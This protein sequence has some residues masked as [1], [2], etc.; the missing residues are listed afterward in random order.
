MH[1]LLCYILSYFALFPNYRLLLSEGYQPDIVYTSRLK[2]AVRSTWTVLEEIDSFYLPVYK[3]WRLNE[4]SYGA[5]TGLSKTETA[6]KLGSNV[7]QAWRNSLKARP[8]LM[9]KTDPYFPG[10]DDRYSDLSEDQIP[11]SESLLDT[12]NR[13]VPLWEYKIRYDI[14]NGNNV[15]VVAH[16]NTLRGLIK[17]IDN[18]GDQE[19]EEVILPAGIPFVYRF[20]QDLT[21]E[22]PPEGSLMQ[23]HC[24][25][26]FLEKPGLLQEAL[27]RQTEWKSKVPGFESVKENKKRTTNVEDSLILLKEEQAAEQW[28]E[29]SIID[30]ED[31][32]IN[33]LRG[34]KLVTSSSST[35]DTALENSFDDPSGFEDFDK[36]ESRKSN[37]AAN[38][39][40][41]A[42]G[43]TQSEQDQVV[44]FIRHGRT[45]HNNLGLFT[46]WEDPP[47]AP[48][49]VED[50]KRAG[51]LLKR[52]GFKFDVVYSSWLQRALQTAWYV[53]DELDMLHL[54]LI[55]SWRLNERMYGALTGKSK[56]MVANEYG[57]EQLIKWRRGFKI[58]PPPVSSYS[59]NYP[60][61][62]YSRTKYVKDIRISWSETLN[63]SWEERK[64]KIHRK[65]PK[66][67][68]LYDCMQRSVGQEV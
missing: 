4:R 46:G 40:P 34:V 61:N 19:I 2:R 53:L 64:F 25:G 13:A 3:S 55:K 5:L 23:V 38:M 15:L 32:D 37:V 14:R 66:H 9:K 52:H 57:E 30:T 51:R 45:P 68:S 39:V 56:A 54:P 36:A 18:I 47:L 41:L 27:K 17:E 7:V 35:K 1:C 67:E 58:R 63:R 22:K 44:V 42:D 33:G 26:K 20:N 31:N 28:A 29:N 49:G 8:P 50:A 24:N 12:M 21:P 16:G 43:A 48:D 11:L 10:N 59:L 60:G 65:F 6:K 62:D